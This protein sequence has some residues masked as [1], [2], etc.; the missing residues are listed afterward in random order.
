M[1][2]LIALDSWDLNEFSFTLG[3]K[4]RVQSLLSSITEIPTPSKCKLKWDQKTWGCTIDII[5]L[6]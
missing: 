4:K 1:K 2:D 5:I 6:L 3:E